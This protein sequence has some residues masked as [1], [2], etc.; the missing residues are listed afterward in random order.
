MMRKAQLATTDFEDRGK[1]YEPKNMGKL[2]KVGKGKE[3][4]SPLKLSSMRPIW[5]P[6]LQT[7]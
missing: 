1:D 2:L 4:N 7:I 3:M 6:E 5:T